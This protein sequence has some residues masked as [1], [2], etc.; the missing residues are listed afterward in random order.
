LPKIYKLVLEI[1][2][3]DE[4]QEKVVEAARQAYAASPASTQNDAG[5][6]TDIPAEEF[7]DGPVTALMEIVQRNSMLEGLGI[8]VCGVSCTGS[9]CDGKADFEDAGAISEGHEEA[10]DIGDEE[11]ELD[12]WESGL[13]L[14]RWPNGEFSVVK[15]ENKRDAMVQLDQW[16]GAHVS[17]LVALETFLAD[18]RLAPILF[19]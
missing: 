19:I 12:E 13:Y 18:F 3:R 7:V 10:D 2:L 4:D 14:C 11:D 15:A 9:D 8:E 17:W 16:A 5:E 6:M 1:I